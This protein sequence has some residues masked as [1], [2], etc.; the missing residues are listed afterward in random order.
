MAAMRTKPKKA[1][2][3]GD[4]LVYAADAELCRRS[5]R[6]FV[7]AAWSVLEPGT[8]LKWNWHMD[9]LCEHLQAMMDGQIQRLAI[10]IGPGHTKSTIVSQCFP[11]WV[12]TRRPETRMLC[13]S[14]DLPLAIRDNRNCRY[15]IESE[16]Y[17]ACY[18]RE[19]KL[20]DTSYDMSPDQ[21]MKSYFAN[22]QQGYRQALSV[23]GKGIGK[24]GDLLIIDDPHDPREGDG[25]REKV[26]EWYKQTWYSRLNDQEKGAM[27][28]VGQRIHE[29]DLCGHVL[30]LGGWEHLCLPEEFDPARRC[31]TS[32]GWCDP[33]DQEGDLLWDAKF[34]ALV[35]AKLKDNLGP[36]GYAAQYDQAPVPATGGTFKQQNERL[37]TQN[38]QTYFLHTPAGIKPVRKEDCSVFIDVDPAISE[39]Q[40]A[41]YMVIGTWAKTPLK[42]LLLLDVRRGRWD[43]NAQQ[44]EIEDAFRE[45]EAEFVAVETIAYQ[46]A[47]F[48]DLVVKGIPCLPFQPHRDKVA[49]AGTASI[50]QGNGKVYFLKDAKWLPELQKELYKFPK[51]PHDDQ[52][53]M[54][55]LASIVVRSRGPL[56]DDAMED[57]IPAPAEAS[58]GLIP[59]TVPLKAS[60]EEQVAAAAVIIATQTPVDAFAW[61]SKRWGEDW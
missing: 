26:L 28:I 20:N 19:F 13:A 15:L 9:A 52:V 34:P 56:S 22:D 36:L 44:D 33:R 59:L 54:I 2:S 6:A 1:L 46:H 37:F 45:S 5:F 42:D 4:Q 49:R 24:R 61:A 10:N 23:C 35:V 31:T 14:T 38:L 53:D 43:H 7:K 25:D 57:D 60:E 39:K 48:Q 16:W 40:G 27:V 18:G 8:A 58:G 50:W 41:D 21:N 12:W 29:D 47:L 55:S 30:K 32:I 11:A 3:T 17:R 51:A